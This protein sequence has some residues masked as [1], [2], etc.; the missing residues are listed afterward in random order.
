MRNHE[1]KLQISKSWAGRLPSGVLR[2]AC[3]VV[4]SVSGCVTEPETKQGMNQE[5]LGLGIVIGTRGYQEI[6]KDLDS[7]GAF[8][9]VLE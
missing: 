5:Q 3:L 4:L 2:I 6:Q 1:T 9:L 8:S 7:L